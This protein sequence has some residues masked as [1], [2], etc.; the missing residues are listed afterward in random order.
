MNRMTVVAVFLI[1]NQKTFL[2]FSRTKTNMNNVIID[3][4]KFFPASSVCAHYCKV[5]ETRTNGQTNGRT[6]EQMNGGRSIAHQPPESV[7]PKKIFHNSWTTSKTG[8]TTTLAEVQ[9]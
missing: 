1:F 9:N 2:I 4:T 5:L 3:R 7:G 6:D 8:Q